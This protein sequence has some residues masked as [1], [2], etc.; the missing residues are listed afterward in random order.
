MEKHLKANHR[1][2]NKEDLIEQS[3]QEYFI[4]PT[5]NKVEKVIRSMTSLT[6]LRKVEIR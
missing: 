3:V 2:T 5:P 6:P 4:L 1:K